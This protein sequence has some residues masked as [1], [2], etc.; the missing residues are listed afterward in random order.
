MSLKTLMLQVAISGKFMGENV[1][2]VGDWA[3]V[4]EMKENKENN[5]HECIQALEN[6]EGMRK[7]TVW[8]K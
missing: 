1:G 5:P 3:S 6:D 4:Y 7:R 2:A 8:D